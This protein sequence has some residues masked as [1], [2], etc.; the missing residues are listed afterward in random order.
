MASF[1]GSELY[2]MVGDLPP[3]V[4]MT[5]LRFRENREKQD[6]L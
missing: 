3:T 6:P 4:G 5:N 2:E 1:G